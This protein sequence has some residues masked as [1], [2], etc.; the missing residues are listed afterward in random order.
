MLGEDE[1]G[2]CPE[3]HLGC[4]DQ[5]FHTLPPIVYAIVPDKAPYDTANTPKQANWG[6]TNKGTIYKS[7]DRV[8]E[9][10]KGWCSTLDLVMVW[11]YGTTSRVD[12]LST[13]CRWENWGRLSYPGG[14]R[15]AQRREHWQ[16]LEKWNSLNLWLHLSI[17]TSLPLPPPV[18][19]AF[20]LSICCSSN[21]T[22]FYA[23]VVLDRDSLILEAFTGLLSAISGACVCCLCLPSVR[24]PYFS[25]PLENELGGPSVPVWFTVLPDSEVSP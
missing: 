19:T 13:I 3:K 11:A 25:F 1:V 18:H 14:P 17:P 22:H 10:N 8:R 20:L 6:G 9:T 23:S 5:F 15:E 2:L 16:G 21:K 12:I 7:V 24:S 4:W